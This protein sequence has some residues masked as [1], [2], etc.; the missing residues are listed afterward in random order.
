MRFIGL[1]RLGEAN[2]TEITDTAILQRTLQP[3]L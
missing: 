1:T 2:I 3:Y